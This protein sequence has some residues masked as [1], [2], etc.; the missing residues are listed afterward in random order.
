MPTYDYKCNNCG[1]HFEKFQSMKEDKLTICP[2]CKNETLVRLIGSGGGLIF[3]GSGFYL[4]DYKNSTA[5]KT[6]S[7]KEKEI[8]KSEDI[9]SVKTSKENTPAVKSEP[10]ESKAIKDN[11]AGKSTET[12]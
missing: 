2:Q 4:T 9:K 10:N 11:P 3:K 1:Y 12:K 6:N 5:E 8:K 7:G